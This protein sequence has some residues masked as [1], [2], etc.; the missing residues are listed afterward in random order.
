MD[1]GDPEGEFGVDS[2]AVADDDPEVATGSN[3]KVRCNGGSDGPDAE[4][5]GDSAAVSRELFRRWLKCSNSDV[6]GFER[7][8]WRL[9]SPEPLE[10]VASEL[11]RH[12]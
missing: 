9:T 3:S 7:L 12:Y 6:A 4:I 10:W 2:D 1:D 11:L 8:M 5:G